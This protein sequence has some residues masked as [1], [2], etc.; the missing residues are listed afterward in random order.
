MTLYPRDGLDVET[1]LRNADLAMY[2]AKRAGRNRL[3]VFAPALHVATTTRAGLV[4]DLHA[5]LANKE[6]ELHYQPIAEIVSG[7]IIKAEAL[8]RW[9]HP[10]YGQ[11]PPSEFIPIAEETGLIVEIGDWVFRS[12]A[13]QAL[14]WRRAFE[15]SFQISVNVSAVQLTTDSDATANF[16]R[17]I[18]QPGLGPGAMII[19]ITESALIDASDTVQKLF[20]RYRQAGFGIAIDDFGTGYSS[21]AY[22]KNF[23]IDYLKIDRGLVSSLTERT[24]DY[25]ICEAV[26]A[27][28]AQTRHPRDRRGGRKRSPACAARRRRLRLRARLSIF[29]PPACPGVRGDVLWQAL[30]RGFIDV[31]R[32][33]RRCWIVLPLST[34]STTPVTNSVSLLAE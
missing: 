21:L 22:L 10:K 2:A 24:R 31:W 32:W 16:D 28:G 5:A 11:V 12:A 4:S 18:A 9:R 13:A 23:D 27:H 30:A 8:A 20:E 29:P 15:P 25:A 1:L 26:I 14:R 7:R 34:D 17:I 33:G 19:E 6:I 3:Q